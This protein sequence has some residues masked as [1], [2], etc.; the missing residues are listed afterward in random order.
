VLQN[1]EHLSSFTIEFPCANPKD[2][3]T[4]PNRLLL[5]LETISWVQLYFFLHI[6]VPM[7]VIQPLYAK[8]QSMLAKTT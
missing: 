7:Y 2:L 5:Q 3:T 8:L 1:T 6:V 4:L